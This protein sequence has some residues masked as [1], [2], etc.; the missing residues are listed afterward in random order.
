MDPRYSRFFS[1][2]EYSK[3]RASAF[4]LAGMG[5]K[6]IIGAR[7]SELARSVASEIRGQHPDAKVVVGPRLDLSNKDDII[8]FAAKIKKEESRCDV[9]I[10]NAGTNYLQPWHTPD[11][12]GG[13][14]QVNYLGPY[15]LTR[16]LEDR[17]VA[18][19]PSRVVNVS[20]VMHRF[21]VIRNVDT[22]LKSWN[23]GSKY[24]NTKICNALFAFELHR[25]LAPYGV[26]S[27]AV[28]P[29]GVASSIWNQSN[30]F[31]TGPIGW[32]I[33]WLY[34]P[35]SDGATAVIHAATCNWDD[36][37]PESAKVNSRVAIPMVQAS[38]KKKHGTTLLACRTNASLAKACQSYSEESRDKYS[39]F[40][41]CDD[42][43]FYAR[44]LFAW[45]G[46]TSLDSR[47]NISSQERRNRRPGLLD[48]TRIMVMGMSTLIHSG[49]DWPLRRLSMN[50]WKPACKTWPVPAAPSCYDRGLAKRL[51]DVS[52]DAVGCP[53]E[54]NLPKRRL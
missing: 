24:S 49:L 16:L 41:L 9:L 35:P 7:N 31:S 26:V 4:A 30:A 8:H 48:I 34:A 13:L 53:R 43:R 14:C 33:R 42:V 18:S 1:Q 39:S 54:V 44:G 47:R 6:V 11:G 52:A 27:C 15:H 3:F 28:D 50:K 23:Q 38:G 46:V 45:P 36:D 10:N 22:L 17:L 32:I 40:D 5:A 20:S 19:A 25:R 21:G 51:W 37:F 29:G 2:S 12:I